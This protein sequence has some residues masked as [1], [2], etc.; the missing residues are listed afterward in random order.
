MLRYIRAL[1]ILALCAC[2]VVGPLILFA[3][4]TMADVRLKT[5]DLLSS[6]EPSVKIG[7]LYRV[8]PNGHVYAGP[9]V[10]SQLSSE[11]P[12]EFARSAGV[13]RY[14]NWLGYNLPLI[15]RLSVNMASPISAEISS[16][17]E[18]P[19]EFEGHTLTLFS[20]ED[21]YAVDEAW[22]KH[23]YLPRL[24]TANSDCEK[25]VNRLYQE[26]QC[27]VLVD[28]TLVIDSKT[29]AYSYDDLCLTF[30][31]GDADY[32]AGPLRAPKPTRRF[33]EHISRLKDEI[34][35]LDECPPEPVS[36]AQKA[37]SL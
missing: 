33:F 25:L 1:L 32:S 6:N 3:D 10:C 17:S 20:V 12:D 2:F 36:L 24:L 29:I 30:D 13:L 11:S 16:F 27:I 21:N 23:I 31:K 7:A 35:L 19:I 26:N 18:H 37:A 8:K 22:L 34:G 4:V 14:R 9:P 5:G 28:K 15:S